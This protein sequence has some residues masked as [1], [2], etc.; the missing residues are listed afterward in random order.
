MTN[1]VLSRRLAV[2]VAADVVGYSRLMEADEAGTLAQLKSIRKELIDPK[3][4]EHRG[5]LVKTTGDGLLMEFS[6]VTDGVQGAIEI[7]EAL[8]ERNSAVPTDRRL[9]FRMGINLGEIITE[10]EDIYGTGV[11]VAARLESLAEPGGICVSASVHEQIQSLQGLGFEDLGEQLVKN[12]SRPVRSFALRTQSSDPIA[13]QRLSRSYSHEADAEGGAHRRMPSIAVLPFTN[14]SGDPEQEYFADGIAEDIITSLSKISNLLVISRNSTFAYK[15]KAVDAHVVGRE[16][17][18]RYVLEGSVRKAG[19][20]VRISAQ[21][22]EAIGRQQLW[23]V[24][25]DRELSDI[26]AL[27]DEITSNVVAALQLKLVE[28][29][30]ARV[31]HRGTKS[32]EAWECLMQGLQLFRHFTKDDNAKARVLFRR[33]LELDPNYAMGLVWLAWT[34]WSDARF[35]WTATPD[36]ALTHADELARC[37]SAIDDNLSEGQALLGAIYLMKKS[38]DEAVVHGRRSIEIEP[39]AAD[40]TATLAMTLSWCGRPAEAAEL[41]KRA[42]RLSPIHSAWY[43]AVLAHAYRLMLRYD[44]AVDVYKQAIALA[45]N[46]IAAHLG[47][48]ICYAQ[49]GQIE[50]ARIQGRE[51]LRVAPKFDMALYAKS[52]TYQDPEDSRR[53]LDAL[54]KAFAP[55]AVIRPPPLL[56]G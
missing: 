52:L 13:Y 47:L 40:A 7:Q 22:V 29:E 5:R 25:F 2:I 19:G 30:Q 48:T 31:W 24:R 16:L 15:G 28:G 35:H 27:Q 43:L 46:Q 38:Y 21:L 55:A 33:A 26:F 53:S 50:L 36:D 23:A 17:N 1:D 3:I 4:A 51:I 44:E 6:S 12:M 54:A 8:A 37:A 34:Y 32:F 39:N 41:V 18:V 9:L 10:G 56:A 45:P 11:N 49:A 20:R 42:M 14:L